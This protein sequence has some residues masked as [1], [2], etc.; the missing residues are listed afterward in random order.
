MKKIIGIVL[1]LVLLVGS[2]RAQSSGSPF[3][4]FGVGASGGS[5]TITNIYPGSGF[6]AG[7]IIPSL[8][9][10]NIGHIYWVAGGAYCGAAGATLCSNSNDCLTQATACLTVNGSLAKMVD[11]VGDVLMIDARGDYPGNVALSKNRISMM[12]YGSNTQSPFDGIADVYAN[13]GTALANSGQYNYFRG[14]QFEADGALSTA[15]IESN[16]NTVYENCGFVG[17]TLGDASTLIM[18]GATPVTINGGYVIGGKYGIELRSFAGQSSKISNV[19]FRNNT[20]AD[21][22]ADGTA[23]LG[24]N[25]AAIVANNYFTDPDKSSYIDVSGA[26]SGA[27]NATGNYFNVTTPSLVRSQLGGLSHLNMKG[28]SPLGDTDSPVNANNTG[29]AAAVATA[30]VTGGVTAFTALGDVLIDSIT[31]Q[32]NSTTITGC[33]DIQWVINETSGA[34]TIAEET[35]GNLSPTKT[36]NLTGAT[37]VPMNSP[38]TLSDGKTIVLKATGSNCTSAGLLNN[39]V[40]ATRRQPYAMLTAG[41]AATATATATATASATATPTATP[42]P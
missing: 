11:A 2:A 32:A 3:G 9:P 24:T 28:N 34:T 42:T 17:D 12:A 33:T 1:G 35:R 40:K 27:L 30:I 19:I 36:L 37:V 25:N 14:I 6:T 39:V 16:G 15:V 13:T 4:G 21:I 7:A 23:Q 8:V 18:A 31:A 41:V 38:F 26:L 20:L 29:A 5:S 22:V 10:T